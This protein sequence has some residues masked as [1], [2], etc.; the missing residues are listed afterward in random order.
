ML[1]NRQLPLYGHIFGLI[2]SNDA[3]NAGTTLN[4]SR[5]CA[6]D[7]QN[8]YLIPIESTFSKV[9]QS[10]GTWSAGAGGNGIDS[11]VVA[12]N[13]WYNVFV[14]RNDSDGSGDVLLSTSISS[15]SLPSGYSSFRRIGSIKTS[16]SGQIIPFTQIDDEF[17]WKTAAWD[18][19]GITTLSS[20]SMLLGLSVPPGLKIL[21]RLRCVMSGASSTYTA[22]ILAC[23]RS[24]DELSTQSAH[25]VSGSG[26]QM[27][28]AI[29]TAGSISEILVRTDTSRQVAA[30]AS[31]TSQNVFHI[32]TVGWFDTRGR[33]S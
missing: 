17:I 4:V 19:Q 27:Q 31:G 22:G 13:S 5:G 32:R 30:I 23:V 25:F 33:L 18:V 7:S 15:P 29:S 28:T 1:I 11:G 14:I 26:C 16:S 12:A 2:M 3:A 21:A 6:A 10:S 8:N 9:I 20:T 24:P